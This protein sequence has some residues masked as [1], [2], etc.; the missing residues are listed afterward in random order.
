M[1]LDS[2]LRKPDLTIYDGFRS[3]LDMEFVIILNFDA[4][5]DQ[6]SVIAGFGLRYGQVTKL[7]LDLDS[8][9]DVTWRHFDIRSRIGVIRRRKLF[10]ILPCSGQNIH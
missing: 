2:D 3:N 10:H 4:T 7:I 9:L 8:D 5:F 6:I 1:Y